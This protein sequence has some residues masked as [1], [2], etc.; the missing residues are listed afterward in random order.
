VVWRVEEMNQVADR[1]HEE[2]LLMKM[3]KVS[4]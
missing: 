3:D 4:V 2:V 1:R